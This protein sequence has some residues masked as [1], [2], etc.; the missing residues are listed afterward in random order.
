MDFYFFININKMFTL[1]LCLAF[2]AHAIRGK[3]DLYLTAKLIGYRYRRTCM[4][5]QCIYTTTRCAFGRKYFKQK[6]FSTFD[7]YAFPYFASGA[8][9]CVR[10]NSDPSHY[11]ADQCTEQIGCRDS[12]KKCLCDGDCGFSC[13]YPSKYILSWLHELH[14][15]FA[16]HCRL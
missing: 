14:A 11:C 16:V 12:R 2:A 1:L 5:L 6:T 15:H 3:M 10:T 4:R 8:N 9:Q 7:T 13:I